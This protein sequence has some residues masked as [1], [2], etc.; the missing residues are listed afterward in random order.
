M[1]SEYFPNCS[2][3][4]EFEVLLKMTSF[5]WCV[6]TLLS[7]ALQPWLKIN[8]QYAAAGGSVLHWRA[9]FK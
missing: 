8:I 2:V 9:S 3:K 7:L 4:D 1:E 6:R 5:F